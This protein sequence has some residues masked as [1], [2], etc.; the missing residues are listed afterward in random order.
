MYSVSSPTKYGNF[1]GNLIHISVIRRLFSLTL[2]R[3]L[4]IHQFV[5]KNFQD[6]GVNRA[7]KGYLALFFFTPKRSPIAPWL[8][9]TRGYLSSFH[10]PTS[11]IQRKW[12]CMLSLR[13]SRSHLHNSKSIIITIIWWY[14]TSNKY[15]HLNHLRIY[16]MQLISPLS[17]FGD[18]LWAINII[19]KI[20]WGF[21]LSDCHH[22][23]H[24]MIHCE[25]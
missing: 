5:S 24:S 23:H 14:T 22:Y 12:L 19:I 1:T 21:I 9:Q 20:I 17:S 16:F 4:K 13:S 15:H 18:L 10:L 7:K 6:A 11:W 3:K 8:S 2:F 25:Q